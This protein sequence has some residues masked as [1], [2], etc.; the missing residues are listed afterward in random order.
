M[1]TM[2]LSTRL[3]FIQALPAHAPVHETEAVLK[4]CQKEVD[5]AMTTY[6]LADV[7][8]IPTLVSIGRTRGIGYLKDVYVS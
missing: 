6:H 3:G 7:E 2:R 5:R 8:D 4:W 1:Q